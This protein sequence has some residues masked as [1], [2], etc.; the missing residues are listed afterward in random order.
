MSFLHTANA[1][2]WNDP[3]VTRTVSGTCCGEGFQLGFATSEDV[4]QWVHEVGHV[5]EHVVFH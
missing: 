4:E 2:E 1:L 3:A 5:P